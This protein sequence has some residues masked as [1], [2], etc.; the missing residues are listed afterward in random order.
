MAQI[1]ERIIFQPDQEVLRLWF[2][3]TAIIP[4]EAEIKRQAAITR[5]PWGLHKKNLLAAAAKRSPEYLI[6][7]SQG[8]LDREHGQPFH[9]D[10]NGP[11]Y[12]KGYHAGY[13]EK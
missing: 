10:G 1:S 5:I 8:K 11:Q 13:T 3:A 9:K 6:G 7:W 4:D 12:M 2:E